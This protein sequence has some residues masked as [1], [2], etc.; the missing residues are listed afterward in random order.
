MSRLTVQVGSQRCYSFAQAAHEA[1]QNTG[2][3]LGGHLQDMH[4]IGLPTETWRD[5]QQHM[6][7][8]VQHDYLEVADS[9]GDGNERHIP[10]HW[11]WL[12]GV[13]WC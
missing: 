8:R 2:R 5:G 7:T 4:D 1:E 3:P 6:D 10:I 11:D 13:A 9:T 12:R